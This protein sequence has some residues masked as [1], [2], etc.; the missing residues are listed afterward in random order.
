MIDHNSLL[1]WYPEISDVFLT[2]KTY[3]ITPKDVYEWMRNGVPDEWIEKIDHNL[4]GR[5]PVFFRTD[6]SSNKHEWNKSCVVHNKNEINSRIINTLDFNYMEDLWP[7]ALVF[8]ELLKP[9]GGKNHADF[10]GFNAFDGFPVGRELRFFF[11]DGKVEC[12]HRYWLHELF[13]TDSWAVSTVPKD[14]EKRWKKLYDIPSD[15]IAGITRQ[16]EK[17]FPAVLRTENWSVDWM[18]AKGKD[19]EYR[20]YLI[21]MALA[22][23]SFHPEHSSDLI[24][25]GGESVVEKGNVP[26]QE[27]SG[28]KPEDFTLL[29]DDK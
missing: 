26:K 6:H 10:G 27:N 29:G 13:V 28:L 7:T 12:V 20:W 14:W 24:S 1:Y 5:Y 4:I 9:Y 11:M 15:E 19:T 23:R 25:P 2:P 3:Y 21:D 16:I 8:R 17:D 22:D 18:Y